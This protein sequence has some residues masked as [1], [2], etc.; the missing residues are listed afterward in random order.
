[1]SSDVPPAQGTTV[2]LVHSNGD[3]GTTVVDLHGL[4]CSSSSGEACPTAA[5][6]TVRVAHASVARHVAAFCAHRAAEPYTD[7]LGK[8]VSAAKSPFVKPLLECQGLEE[9]LDPWDLQF[10]ADVASGGDDDGLPRVLALLAASEALGLTWL[11]HL[12]VVYV[13]DTVRRSSPDELAK[14]FGRSGGES[15]EGEGGGG[16]V[17]VRTTDQA[18]HH[19]F[20]TSLTYTGRGDVV[21]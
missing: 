3:G 5:P 16:L 1:M 17:P 21:P 20:I 6:E 10:T 7:A 13:A 4:S 12:L 18:P 11:F 9:L 8:V 15:A 14:A 2:R 19:R